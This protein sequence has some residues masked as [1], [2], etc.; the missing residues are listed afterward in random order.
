MKRTGTG[1]VRP[2][3]GSRMLA[4]SVLTVTWKFPSTIVA[5]A[6]LGVPIA[7]FCAEGL[8]LIEVSVTVSRSGPSIC[9]SR[10]ATARAVS[11]FCPVGKT[12]SPPS[13]PKVRSAT[14]EIAIGG[15][16][17]SLGWTPVT[18]V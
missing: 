7:K 15:V 2:K 16:R 14:P 10:M 9:A 1:S 4:T 6:E 11:V 5:V 17:M 8:T 18:A 12:I 3:T 13:W